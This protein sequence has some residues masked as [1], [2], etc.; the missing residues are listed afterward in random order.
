MAQRILLQVTQPSRI[1]KTLRVLDNVAACMG[2]NDAK[3]IE[4]DSLSQKV[5]TEAF[6]ALIFEGLNSIF[7]S[8]PRS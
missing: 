5:L 1:G 7:T 2:R 4:V 6:L 3:E 8:M